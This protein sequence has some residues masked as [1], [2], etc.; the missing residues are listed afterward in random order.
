MGWDRQK[1]EILECIKVTVQLK[2]LVPYSFLHIHIIDLSGDSLHKGK[3]VEGE[4]TATMSV[5]GNWYISDNVVCEI[6]P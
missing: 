6:G 5:K 3:S 4:R 1:D 2:D